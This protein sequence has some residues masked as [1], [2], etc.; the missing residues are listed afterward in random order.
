MDKT[1]LTR[2]IVG[3]R[4]AAD[5]LPPVY[6]AL[7]ALA[8]VG[9]VVGVHYAVAGGYLP[10]GAREH[11]G[12]FVQPA[13]E[14]LGLA[15]V[16]ILAHAGGPTDPP[17]PPTAASDDRPTADTA[18][19]EIVDTAPE[20]TAPPPGHPLSA[21]I[22]LLAALAVAMPACTARQ[23]EDAGKW[24]GRAVEHAAQARDV[25]QHAYLTACRDVGARSCDVMRLLA[26]QPEAPPALRESVD[27]DCAELARRCDHAARALTLAGD[28]IR[29]ADE[30]LGGTQ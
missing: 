24:A 5:R 16:A 30:T 20:D 27:R 23:A 26:D 25:A 8:V 13:L 1:I 4:A 6:R 12:A 11:A 2:I 29:E 10:A 19:D 9:A 18:P 17:S 22:V 28:I 14:V 15:V 7:V 3:A 21:A